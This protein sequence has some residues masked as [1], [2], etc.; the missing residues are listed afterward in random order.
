MLCTYRKFNYVYIIVLILARS[1]KC[2]ELTQAG[3]NAGK[4]KS[5]SCWFEFAGQII[6]STKS[7][8]PKPRVKP[9]IGVVVA[10]WSSSNLSASS[11]ASLGDGKSQFLFDHGKDVDENAIDVVEASDENISDSDGG[12]SDGGYDNMSV[13]SRGKRAQY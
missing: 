11:F 12:Y 10:F 4:P 1:P 13:H 2:Y 5:R 8:K 3:A 7:V 9:K 6:D